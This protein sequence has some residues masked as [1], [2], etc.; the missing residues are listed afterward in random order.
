MALPF[1]LSLVIAALFLCPLLQDYIEFAF[2]DVLLMSMWW[3]QLWNS[4]LSSTVAV[5]F[6]SSALL[7]IESAFTCL[8]THGWRKPAADG[9]VE[10]GRLWEKPGL[11][12]RKMGRR[13]S[14]PVLGWRKQYAMQAAH[15]VLQRTLRGARR[16][17]SALL[18]CVLSALGAFT[19]W[20]WF[21]S[22]HFLP[23]LLILAVTKAETVRLWIGRASSTK[24]RGGKGCRT[25]RMGTW[26]VSLLILVLVG[27]ESVRAAGLGASSVSVGNQPVGWMSAVAEQATT[28]LITL[29]RL[30]ENRGERRAKAKHQA[31]D[32]RVVEGMERNTD[33]LPM[34]ADGGGLSRSTQYRQ[35]LETPVQRTAR[36]AGQR[37]FRE[38]RTPDQQVAE[39]ERLAARDYTARQQSMTPAETAAHAAREQG[40][41]DARLEVSNAPINKDAAAYEKCIEGACQ[42][43]SCA[44]CANENGQVSMKLLQDVPLAHLE[45]IRAMYDVART[46]DAYAE[47]FASLLGE[48]HE[49]RGL[50][51]GTKYICTACCNT[52]KA[53]HLELKA[54]TENLGRPTTMYD[55]RGTA[56]H[57]EK[58]SLI[59]VEASHI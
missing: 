31:T 29:K 4:W 55:M 43:V 59:L 1:F 36:L 12:R 58:S 41:R 20:V 32:R 42:M 7:Q 26:Y 56:P 46:D 37:A 18:L 16:L 35:N 28:R 3:A 2:N 51:P 39:T 21:S 50:M 33:M 30:A 52:L 19:R 13:G 45:P 9:A 23:C 38:N 34:E 14:T 57:T 48:N 47:V 54:V 24:R 11:T 15:L 8:N 22:S 40:R 25:V 27:T 6:P 5:F 44:C 17:H 53:K 49:L 10:W